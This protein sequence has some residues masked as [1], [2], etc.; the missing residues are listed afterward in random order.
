M[1]FRS[2]NNRFTFNSRSDNNYLTA[3]G[4]A[5]VNGSALI[6]TPGRNSNSEWEFIIISKGSEKKSTE[7]LVKKRTSEV[8][9]KLADLNK[10]IKKKGYKFR[11][12]AHLLLT[13]QSKRS[14]ALST[15]PLTPHHLLR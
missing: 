10:T 11:V 5:S 14:P 6:M 2:G 9:R 13:K 1:L 4:N 3:A 12:K 15:C 7:D 8:N